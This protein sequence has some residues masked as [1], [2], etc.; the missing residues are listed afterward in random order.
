MYR[1]PPECSGAILIMVC[2]LEIGTEHG[3]QCDAVARQDQNEGVLVRCPQARYR[4]PRIP[5]RMVAGGND[6]GIG[7]RCGTVRYGVASG[8]HGPVC[9]Q[10]SGDRPTESSCR[11]KYCDS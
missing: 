3:E 9:R 2:V 6:G 7:T 8:K 11:V 4:H 1:H 5:T 10:F